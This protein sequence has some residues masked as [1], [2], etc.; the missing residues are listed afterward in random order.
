[1]RKN[2]YRL[3]R[4]R[5]L[6]CL[7]VALFPLIVRLALLPWM[8][9]PNPAVHDEFSYL[10][11]ADTFASGRL[12]N[13][14]HPFWIHFESF[15]IIQQPTYASKYPP[16]QPLVLAF[17]QVLGHPWI[18]VWLSV[19]AMCAAICWMLQG[20]LPPGGALIGAL[21]AA[22]RLGVTDYWMNSYWGG[23]VP[24]A[25][26]ALVLGAL[27]RL[28]RRMRARDAV[29][30]ALG[31][32]IL[33]N[34]R[35][36]E[37]AIIGGSA[38]VILAVTC[39]RRLKI[40]ALMPAAAVLAL[41][42]AAMAYYNFRVTGSPLR[43]PYQVHEAQYNMSS[44]F[45]WQ[46]PKPEPV[47]HHAVMRQFWAVWV[48]QMDQLIRAHP[49]TGY[50][51]K[52]GLNYQFYLGH[53]LLAAPLFGLPFVW[54]NRRVRL[55][56]L[57]AGVFL[58]A[59]TMETT[60]W[61]HYLAPITGLIFLLLMHGFFGFRFW[62]SNG[63]PMGTAV[64]K[65]VGMI[66]GLQ[67]LI[68]IVFACLHLTGVSQFA[69]ERKAIESR[70]E[71]EPGEQLVLVRYGPNHSLH[72]EWVYNRADIDRAKVVWAREMTPKEDAPLIEY[73]QNRRVWLLEADADPPKLTRY[74]AMSEL[75]ADKR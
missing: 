74:P 18:G 38:C 34:S 53:W 1:M 48:M 66:F 75:A 5:A 2:F 29:I 39:F 45:L 44:V 35:P 52:V 50:F 61:P 64:T 65:P 41:T 4:K 72:D 21:L 54:K 51:A 59:M 58:A 69:A 33:A 49:I 32:A 63:K 19:G 17:G 13:P 42:F 28:I 22:M 47:Y 27:P 67:F 25:G 14:P 10:L 31:L 12:T 70:L 68:Y 8:P 7:A 20:W 37:G 6:A 15:H 73:F 62:R 57:L 26:G 56:L 71:A 46:K 55:A 11:G 23:A 24:A 36:F 43:M 9:V 30:F 40:V 60:V 16:L 3:A